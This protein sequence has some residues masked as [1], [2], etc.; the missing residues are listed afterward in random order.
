MLAMQVQITLTPAESKRLIAKAV[1]LLPEVR[2]ALKL[3]MIVVGLGTTNAHVAEELLG[4]KIDRGRFVAGLVLPKGTCTLPVKKR[5]KEFVLVRGKPREVA[6]DEVLEKLGP[7]DVV[8]KGANAL[9]P[10]GTAGIFLASRRGGTI[11]RVLGYLKARGVNLILPIGMEK[12]VPGPLEEV[13]KLAG[14]FRFEDAT[15]C[16]VGLMPVHGKV[17]TELEAVRILAE[18]HALVMGAGGVSGAEGSVTLVVSGTPQQ[19]RKFMGIVRE[20]KGMRDPKI[21]TSCEACS[22]PDCF[23]SLHSS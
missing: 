19:V 20:I 11:G 10:K 9:D 1:V 6:L 14:I 5:L 15:G 4:K 23:Y 12:L 21:E 2:K 7:G 16:P 22:H 18:A 8:I 3:G 17:V 13:S